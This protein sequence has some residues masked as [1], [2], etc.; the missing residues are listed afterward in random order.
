MNSRDLRYWPG[1]ALTALGVVVL[2]IS[3]YLHLYRYDLT[4]HEKATFTAMT[5]IVAVA[6]AILAFISGRTFE[7][8]QISQEQTRE[9]MRKLRSLRDINHDDPLE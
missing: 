4:D 3:V 9:M 7:R 1:L 2:T 6:V 8:D 5:F